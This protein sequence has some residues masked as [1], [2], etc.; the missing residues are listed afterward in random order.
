MSWAV[1]GHPGAPRAILGH[2]GT[3]W[4]TQDHHG[5]PRKIPEH[6]GTSLSTQPHPGAPRDIL[7][8]PG[9]PGGT[10]SSPRPFLEHPQT[11]WS[12]RCHPEAPG[13]VLGPP[14]EHRG[15]EEPAQP[16]LRWVPRVPSACRVPREM[17]VEEGPAVPTQ[18]RKP[19][20]AAALKGRARS[21]PVWGERRKLLRGHQLRVNPCTGSVWCTGCWG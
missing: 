5:A 18:G 17:R 14:P 11:S 2:P 13:D 16:R 6:L 7:E 15:G 9:P 20:R 1:H 3:L 21:C 12:S 19:G 10:W 8:H 4:S